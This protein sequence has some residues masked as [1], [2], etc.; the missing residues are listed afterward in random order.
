[1]NICE[2]CESEF[3]TK[4]NLVRHKRTS[5]ACL[6]LRNTFNCECN[7]CFESE[8]D[9]IDHKNECVVYYKNKVKELEIENKILKVKL[10]SQNTNI[11]NNTETNNIQVNKTTKT[12]NIQINMNILNLSSE[13]LKTATDNY[14]MDHYLKGPDGM[15]E[16]LVEFVITEEDG[17]PLYGCS[18]KNRKHFFYLNENKEKVEDIKAQ[19]LIKA[20]TPEIIDKLKECKQTRNFE[21]VDKFFGE[22]SAHDE[23]VMSERIKNKK[24]YDEALGPKFIN[25]LVEKTYT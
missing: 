21:I 13:R 23:K 17:K 19:K 12:N 7:K 6:K 10:E 16:W 9:L 25:K 18:D 3:K 20:I 11:T 4:S 22:T 15:V 1:M 14:N 24:L 5:K 8:A 2:Y